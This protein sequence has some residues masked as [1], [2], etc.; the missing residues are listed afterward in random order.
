MAE[1]LGSGRRRRS[2][3][4]ECHREQQVCHQG[5]TVGGSVPILEEADQ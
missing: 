3:V 5:M 1:P 4:C 2:V